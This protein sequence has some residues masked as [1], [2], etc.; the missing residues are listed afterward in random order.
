LRKHNEKIVCRYPQYYAARALYDN[1]KKAQQKRKAQEEQ[2]AQ[3]K[4]KFETKT[5]S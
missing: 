4:M 3:Q 1:I 2:K 5:K